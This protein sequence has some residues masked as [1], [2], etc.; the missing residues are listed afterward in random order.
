MRPTVKGNCMTMI[1]ITLKSFRVNAPSSNAKNAYFIKRR[2][3]RV[4][5]RRVSAED[6]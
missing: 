2:K 3:F 6:Y 1:Q 4:A 5:P